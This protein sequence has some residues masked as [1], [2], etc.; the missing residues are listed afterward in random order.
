MRA[1]CTSRS[2]R[3]QRAERH[4]REDHHD[5]DHQQR[6]DHAGRWTA[7]SGPAVRLHRRPPL[8]GGRRPGPATVI[9]TGRPRLR[10]CRPCRPGPRRWRSWRCWPWRSRTRRAG[11]RPWSGWPPPRP[12]L[13]TG[14][15][16]PRRGRRRC[17]PGPGGR[18]PGHDPGG[19]RRLR[20]RR[21]VHRRRPAWAADAAAG[22]GA[23]VHR[24]LRRSPPWSRPCSA[25][26]R[27]S[28]C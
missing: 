27:P 7:G 14:I 23:A 19:R 2:V 21:A 3:L 11:S 28:C 6:P 5:R 1:A 16:H 26:T 17:A 8:L 9:L 24:R 13:A 4:E 18:V 10:A 15:A 20:P 25:S 12:P 22:A